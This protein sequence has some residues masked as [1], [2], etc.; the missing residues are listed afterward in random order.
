MATVDDRTGHARTIAAVLSVFALGAIFAAVGGVLPADAL[1]RSERLVQAVPHL[2]AVLSL[3]A[4]AC[5]GL[6]VRWIR[7][8]RVQ[9]HRAAMLAAFAQFGGFLV[10]YLYKVVLAG[11]TPFP[12]PEV[13]YTAVYLPL[14]TVHILLAVVC[15]PLLF[16]VLALATIHAVEDLPRTPHPRIGRLAAALWAISFTLGLVVYALLYLVY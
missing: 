3:G 9:R 16:Y 13:M 14:L 1:P 8:G 4:L 15:V 10:L 11:A 5:I 6:G 7:T 12:G 2:N